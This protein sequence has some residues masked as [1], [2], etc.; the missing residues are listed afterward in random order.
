MAE[1]MTE[2]AP[3]VCDHT[4]VGVIVEDEEGRV[5]LGQRVKPPIGIAPSAGHIDQLGTPPE[6]AARELLEET[7]LVV[8]VDALAETIIK[9]Q[10]VNNRCRR[11]DGLYHVWNVY[12]A[13]EYT[14][15]VQ[16]KPDEMRTW[17]WHDE[18]KL[19]ALAQ[20]TR[21]YE[22]GRINEDDW[23]ENP[24]LEPVWLRFFVELNYI[25]RWPDMPTLARHK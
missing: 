11:S 3:N 9:D 16:E 24:G 13:K 17:A 22:A 21:A 12:R 23:E 8:A 7:G 14:G 20:R 1:A 2:Q 10:R 15:E 19:L 18:A 6:A 5:L 4:S 25:P